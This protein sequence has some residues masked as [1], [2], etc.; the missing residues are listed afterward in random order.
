MK[1]YIYSIRS[2]Q[3]DEIYIGSTEERLSQRMAKHRYS[4]K[5]WKKG[6]YGYCTSFE[7]LKYNDAYI[8][9]IVEVEVASKQELCKIEGENI[10]KHNCVNKRIAGRTNAEYNKD[11]KEKIVEYRAEYYQDNKEKLNKQQAIYNAEHKEQRAK[12]IAIPYTCMCGSICS[13]GN[14]YIHFKTKKH[15]LY[16]AT[17]PVVQD[18]KIDVNIVLQPLKCRSEILYS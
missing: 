5:A 17:H 8:E 14:K 7:I 15:I 11:Y 10:R 4:Y 6:T 1:G 2:H 12:Y 13:T 16:M 18:I 9:L 3:T